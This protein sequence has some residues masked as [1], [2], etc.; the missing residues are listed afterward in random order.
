M[1]GDCQIIGEEFE[2]L[3]YRFE[4]GPWLVKSMLRLRDKIR[5]NT[6]RTSGQSLARVIVSDFLI[7]WVGR[8]WERS[9]F[10]I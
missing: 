8:I 3:G 4:A 2:L 5:A 1:S 7:A 6:R 10:G 9:S